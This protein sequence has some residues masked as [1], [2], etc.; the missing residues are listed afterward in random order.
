MRLRINLLG[1]ILL[2][3]TLL[4]SFYTRAYSVTDS[5]G[6]VEF[7]SPPQR[8]VVLDWDLLEQLLT[9]EITP[10][11]ATELES[12][13][14]WVVDPVVPSS[15]KEVG[16]RAEPNLEQIA[17]L[18]PDVIIA[19]SAQE[20]LLPLLEKIAPVVYLSNFARQDDS[21]LVAITHFKTLARLFEKTSFADEYLV[22][23]DKRFAELRSQLERAFIT[24]P[25]VAV[26]RFSSLS[27]IFLYTENSTLNYVLE[28][29]ALKPAILVPA[30][31]WGIEQRRINSLQFINDGYV[32]YIKPFV[33][34][35][36]LN[37]SILWQSMPFVKQ[38]RINS[39]RPVWNYGG[40]FS[41]QLMA[42][43]LTESLLQVAPHNDN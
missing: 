22:K 34:E 13:K 40:V 25:S 9:L 21:G 1:L 29:L 33:E 12:Y 39:V 37:D 3:S 16:T 41:L 23:M 15:V 8:V 6:I 31:P 38:G 4:C 30:R 17:A 11:G 24:K 18:K 36:K 35:K 7:N 26:I 32:L 28:Q 10:V 20:D 5:R 27:T 14:Q 19:S 42:E 2:T 43:A